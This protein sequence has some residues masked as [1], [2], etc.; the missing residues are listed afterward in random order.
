MWV[1]VKRL[2]QS[3]KLNQFD[4]DIIVVVKNKLDTVSER[5][6]STYNG[7]KTWQI[8]RKTCYKLTISECDEF[9]K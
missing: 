1:F 3:Q 5:L 9:N 6:E 8:Y 7:E 4:R 2:F